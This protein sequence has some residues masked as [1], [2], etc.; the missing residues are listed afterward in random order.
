MEA[1]TS[2]LSIIGVP[3]SIISL[4]LFLLKFKP[5][6]L[7]SSSPIEKV[8]MTKERRLTVRALQ[9]FVHV[10]ISTLM[11]AFMT[12][13]FHYS[14]I[15]YNKLIAVICLIIL[16]LF[17]LFFTISNLIDKSYTTSNLV[18]KNILIYLSLIY[19]TSCYILI[20]YYSGTTISKVILNNSTVYILT[21]I[22][23]SL[24]FSVSIL[25]PATYHVI[26]FFN[27]RFG[28]LPALYV[29]DGVKKWFLYHPIEND[30]ILLG[31]S[32]SIDDCKEYIIKNRIDILNSSIC[33]FNN[34]K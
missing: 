28:E 24:I 9:Y 17:F 16:S 32:P 14:K 13:A 29:A 25:I 22:V 20:S 4:L 7:Y 11:L 3:A 12:L 5:V 26:K 19:I 23:L 33:V 10:F 31:D 1:L 34:E 18:S 2:L 21:S 6:T 8:I 15:N 27:S 30:L